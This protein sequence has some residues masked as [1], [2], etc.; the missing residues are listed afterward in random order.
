MGDLSSAR[1]YYSALIR[2]SHICVYLYTMLF[3]LFFE[4]RHIL[5][6]IQY[7]EHV[8]WQESLNKVHKMNVICSNT[9]TKW[10]W[11]CG[12]SATN[13]DLLAGTTEHNNETLS[14]DSLWNFFKLIYLLLVIFSLFRHSV[15]CIFIYIR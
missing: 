15:Q 13:N 14:K 9:V 5:F 6:I 12:A 10:F 7:F 8:R 2:A 3:L 1:C 11:N 4:W